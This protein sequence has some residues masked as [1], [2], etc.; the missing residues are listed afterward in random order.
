MKETFLFYLDNWEVT[1]AANSD[2]PGEVKHKMLLSSETMEG[3]RITGLFCVNISST[4]SQFVH[5]LVNSFIEMSQFLLSK[6]EGL[7][8][9]SERVSQDS[10]E[11]YFGKQRARGGCNENPNLQQCLTNAAALRLQG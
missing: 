1:V 3:L 11:N 8:L 10:L 2:V 4:Y 7:F 6:S 9:L 5:L